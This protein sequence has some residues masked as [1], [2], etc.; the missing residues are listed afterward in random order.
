M[1]MMAMVMSVV[2]VSADKMMMDLPY[3]Y[4]NEIGYFTMRWG[5]DAESIVLEFTLSS[6]VWIGL[7]IGCPNGSEKC[8]MIVGGIGEDGNGFILDTYEPHGDRA[9]VNDTEL[10]GTYDLTLL[11]AS[12]SV[13]E[14]TTLR[15]SRKVNT[16]DKFDHAITSGEM[17][18]VYAWCSPPFCSTLETAHAPGDWNIISVDM[19][20]QEEKHQSLLRG[21]KSNADCSPGS[22]DLCSCSQLIRAG[23]IKSF[24]DCTQAAAIAYCEKHHGTCP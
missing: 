5:Y 12:Y 24:D 23:V 4:K 18:L 15:F 19:K 21:S 9:S 11:K 14:G 17:D 6:D 10:G 20:Y 22:E 3:E 2:L 13:Q 1:M 7:G 8:D 16:G